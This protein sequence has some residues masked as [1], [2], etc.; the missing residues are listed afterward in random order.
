MPAQHRRGWHLALPPQRWRPGAA[1]RHGLLRLP[2]RRRH[3][4]TRSAQGRRRVAPVRAIEIKLSQGAK[5]GL[6]GLLPAAKMTP[7]IAEIRGIPLGQDC[8]V[9]RRATPPSTTST[10]CSTSSRCSPTETGAAGRHQVGGR[11]HG[12]LAAARRHDESRRARRRLHHHRRRRGRH[13]R[14]AADLHR[15][16]AL[17]FRIGFSRV[18]GDLRRARPHR[19]RHLHRLR[20]ARPARRTPS[21]RSR[22]V[23]TWSTSAARR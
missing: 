19:R 7:E 2:Q 16:V 5:P 6:G 17:P 4:P 9:A 21:S 20:Q 11:R 3:L 15:R 12:V 8:V 23:P 18:Y 10:R 13:R 14:R 22:S 1:D